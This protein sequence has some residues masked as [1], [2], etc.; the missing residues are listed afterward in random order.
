MEP[1]EDVIVDISKAREKYF[2]CSGKML[3]PCPA[4]VKALVK[5]IPKNKLVTT[6]LLRRELADQFNVE[7]TCP[8]ATRKALQAIAK[9]SSKVAYWQVVKKN[10]EL[11]AYFPGGM[12]DHATRLRKEGFTIDTQGKAPKVQDFKA[13]LVQ[14]D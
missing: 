12:A 9:D 7:V 5:K 1:Q 10:G 11:I 13:S 3:L 6:E 8:V 4:T 14:F 2:G